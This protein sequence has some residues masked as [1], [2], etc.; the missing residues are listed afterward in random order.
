[1]AL[2]DRRVPGRTS[3]A[4]GLVASAVRVPSNQN[5]KSGYRRLIQA[6]QQTALGYYESEGA[7]WYPSQFYGRALSRLRLFVAT[8]TPDGEREPLKGNA[9]ADEILGRVQDPGGGRSNMLRTY[10]QLRFV[11][12]ESYML[13]T[14]VD[15]R[16]EWEMVSV[17]ELRINPGVGYVRY[18]APN[19][20]PETLVDAPDGEFEAVPGGNEAVVYR[21]W[22]RSPNFSALADAPT[23]GVL[24][25]YD[26]LA[27]LT[28]AELANSKSRAANAGILF[29][30]NEINF[31]GAGA[32][33]DDPMQD[34]FMRDLTMAMTA[35]I[36]DPGEASASVPMISRIPAELIGG[37]DG[38]KG[39]DLLKLHDPTEVSESELIE[40]TIR[41]IAAGLDIPPEIMLGIG[42]VNHW[43]AWAIQDDT[44]QSHLGPAAQGFCDDLTSAYFRPACQAAG[45]DGWENLVVMYDAAEI[46]NHPDKGK[47]AQEA[48][49]AGAI[50]YSTY[51]AA[52]GFQDDDA[53]TDDELR[54][55]VAVKAGNVDALNTDPQ[56]LSTGT[57]QTDVATQ[58]TANR[59]GANSANE[60]VPGPPV[61]PTAEEVTAA[62]V[63]AMANMAV[64]RC[65]ELAGSRLRTQS[66]GCE[67][68]V[69][70]L[71][72]VDQDLVASVL[73]F[74]AASELGAEAPSDLVA[75]GGKAFKRTLAKNGI[76]T[77]WATRLAELVELHAARTLFQRE[78]PALPVG[79]MEAARRAT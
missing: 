54:T 20:S 26:L 65:R 60:V 64:E 68:C 50:G 42:D 73:G 16:E 53:P 38:K 31:Q 7:C 43:S 77:E 9:T 37:A 45:I 71:K 11:T 57:D 44:W 14:E 8:V 27:R 62:S 46:I 67:S 18:R 51:R 4:P 10:G 34:P 12:G 69:E 47:D 29:L 58:D 13:V 61:E 72:D 70:K 28:A 39:Y 36:R 52:R 56:D 75:G 49:D 74:E 79:F 25:L 2:F 41:R 35:S 17:N 5:E 19:L 24:T 33:S 3:L 63:V 15:G 66:R 30:A 59:E 21:F 48:F 55:M 40:K 78:A 32:Q 1:M 76:S 6:W 22:Q 23:R